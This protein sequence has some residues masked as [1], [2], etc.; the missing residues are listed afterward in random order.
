[1]PSRLGNITIYADDPQRLAR[2]WAGAFGYPVTE[3][4][5]P[6]VSELL[7]AGLTESDLNKRGLAEPAEGQ[8]GPRFFFQ[9]ADAPKVGRNRLHLDIQT[10]PG[11]RP[12]RGELEQEKD[13]LVAL[14]AEVVRLVDQSWGPWP[15]VYFQMRDPEG[16]EFCLQ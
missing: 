7:A 10:T 6:F 2:F 12:S 5:E 13:R 9:H 11:R 15:E 8:E 1:M 16:N 4:E 3:W 14:G